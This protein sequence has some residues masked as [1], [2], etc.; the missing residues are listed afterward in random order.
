[1]YRAMARIHAAYAELYPRAPLA[2]ARGQEYAAG[3]VAARIAG[4]DATASA[5][6][7]I[8][9]LETAFRFSP[10]HYTTMGGDAGLPAPHGRRSRADPRRQAGRAHDGGAVRRLP[11]DAAPLP[12]RDSPGGGAHPRR[13]HAVRHGDPGGA[14]SG[15]PAP[16]D[17]QAV[18]E[19]TARAPHHYEG[20]W[21][22]LQ[23]WCHTW[24]GSERLAVKFA[25]RAAAKAPPGS[26][27]TV[28][29]PAAHVEHDESD[30][31][32]GD[33]TPEMVAR[34]DAGLADAAAADPTR[35]RL[36]E[37]RHPLRTTSRSRAGT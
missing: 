13:P 29:P 8:P 11:P 25:E 14:R 18:A 28:L 1:M 31:A 27:L 3:A 24:R 33:R 35:P 5:L 23:Y 21:W 15:L 9:V 6:R 22:A 16:R 30:G 20:H 10:H 12:R 37:P 19:T 4:R 36:P 26:L 34:V 17:G 2:D 7:E 32:E